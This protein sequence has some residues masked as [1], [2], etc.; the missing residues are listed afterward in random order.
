M[1]L[2]FSLPYKP[3]GGQLKTAVK[4]Y[5]IAESHW[6]DLSTGINPCAWPIPPIPEFCW[7]RLPDEQDQL[8]DAASRYYRTPSLLPI[9]GTQ[10]AIQTLPLLRAKSQVAV[11][12]LGYSEHQHNW[13]RLG[14][15]T[16]PLP[17]DQIDNALHQFDVVV[18]INP[19]NPTGELINPE[20]LLRWHAQ[21]QKR[22]GWLIVDE[23]FMDTTPQ[24]SLSQHCPLPGLIV[25]RSLGKFFGLAGIRCGFIIATTSLLSQLQQAL[26]PW[27]LNSPARWIAEQALQDTTWQKATSLRLAHNAQQ[28]KQTLNIP[29]LSYVGQIYHTFAQRGILLRLLDN[30]QGLRFGL[31]YTPAHWQHLASGLSTIQNP[32]S[33]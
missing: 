22:N 23:A 31:P 24:Y 10:A 20:T 25:L 9:A 7:N 12:V 28:L 32:Q 8:I 6:L 3:H 30:K 11:P 1:A 14:H 18:I 29:S 15:D 19:N 21:L 5:G 2:D 17:S 26:G 27:T 4:R 16:Y 13:S 33:L